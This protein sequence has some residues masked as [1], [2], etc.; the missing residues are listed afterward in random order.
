MCNTALQKLYTRQYNDTSP[1]FNQI[2]NANLKDFKILIYNGDVD[3]VCNHIGNQW[4][5]EN[6]ASTNGLQ[7]SQPH[8]AWYYRNQIGGYLK[9]FKKGNITIDLV[10]V[11][12][13]GFLGALDRPGKNFRFEKMSMPLDMFFCQKNI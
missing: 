5:V 10:T 11:K 7:V 8:Q 6:L 2:I 1:F 13:A 4:F 3:F 12:G 9:E